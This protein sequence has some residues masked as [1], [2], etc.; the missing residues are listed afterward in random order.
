MKEGFKIY[1]KGVESIGISWGII[2]DIVRKRWKG[3]IQFY[4]K[5]S[6]TSDKAYPNSSDMNI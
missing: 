4:F 5:L 3:D 6:K 2:G 1:R